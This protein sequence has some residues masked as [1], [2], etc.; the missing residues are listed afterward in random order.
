MVDRDEVD[1]FLNELKQ[2]IKVFGI[3]YRPRDQHI[4]GLSELGIMPGQREDLILNLKPEN[5][6]TGPNEDTYDPSKPHYYEFGIPLK[7][8]EIYVKLNIGLPNKSI[9]CM[10]FHLAKRKMSF[11]LKT[12]ENEK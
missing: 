2:K 5:Y 1:E 8:Q 10:S 3:A 7:H 9:D 11:P 6:S 4:E 12:S